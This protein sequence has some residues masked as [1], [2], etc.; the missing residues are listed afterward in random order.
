MWDGRQHI[1]GYIEAKDT[2]VEYLDKIIGTKQLKRYL[3][4]FHNL[5]LTNFFEF[6]LY[7]DGQLID[8]VKIGRPFIVHKLKT[9]PPVEKETEFFKLLEKYF[10]FSLPKTYTAKTLAI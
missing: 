4:T 3:H 8:T 7:R 5:I 1:I 2:S 10:S 6:R 9:I